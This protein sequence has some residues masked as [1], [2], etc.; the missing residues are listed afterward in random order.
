MVKH[1]QIVVMLDNYRI[2]TFTENGSMTDSRW[3]TTFD[4]CFVVGL[5]L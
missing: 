2:K 4:F 1:K 5:R 3:K